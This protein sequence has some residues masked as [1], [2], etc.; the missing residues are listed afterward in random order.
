[1][2]LCITMKEEKSPFYF[3][4]K[5]QGTK[6]RFNLT[7]YLV[8]LIHKIECKK[9]LLESFYSDPFKLQRLETLMTQGNKNV[10]AIV[11][12]VVLKSLLPELVQDLGFVDPFLLPSCPTCDSLPAF[13]RHYLGLEVESADKR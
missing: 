10:Q 12:E 11:C 6:K 9:L 8:R 5:T 1:M 4:Q 2:L 3:D 13:R 7:P